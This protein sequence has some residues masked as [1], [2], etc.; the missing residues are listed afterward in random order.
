MSTASTTPPPTEVADSA[1]LDG[2]SRLRI[3]T[4]LAVIVLYTEIAPLQ[5]IMVAAALQ[6]VSVSFPTVGANLNWSIIILGLVGSAV[7]PVLGKL[8]DVAGKRRIFVLCG[9]FF[10]A[11]CLID[12]LTSSWALFLIGRGLQAFA[13]ATMIIAF[14]LIRDLM[15]RKYVPVGLGVAAAGAGFSGVLGP[16]LGGFLV[17]HFGWR[18]MFW[19]L[20][21]FVL[22]MT[23]IVLMLVPESPLRVR[24]RINPIGA[25][26]LSA[27]TLLVLL[28]LDK[29]QDWGWGRPTALAWVIA[30]VVLLAVFFVVESRIATP[31]MD[32]KLLRNPRVSLV[33]LIG[34]LGGALLAVHGYAVSYMTQTPGAEQ[35]KSTVAQGVIAQVK[36][37]NGVTLPASAV[38]VTLDPGYSYG[39]GFGLLSYAL[40]LGMWAGL[41]GMIAGPI[42]GLLARR[43]GARIP[44]I[45]GLVL[46]TVFGGVFALAVPHYSWSL[47]L[48]FSVPFGVGFGLFQ[49]AT[50][51]LLV[52]GVPAEQQGITTGMYGVTTG[53]AAAIGLA[54]TT[55]LLNASPV[56]AHI[57]VM[58]HAAAQTIPQVFADRGYVASYW[59]LSGATLIAL[60]VALFM[61]HGRTPATGGATADTAESTV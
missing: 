8:S 56:V 10:I 4:V 30:G 3:F 21:G 29:G 43:V 2:A 49:A 39:N 18:A 33:L 31:L 9:V 51:I 47:F 6:K 28:Y 34:L 50:P 13:V 58:G 41:I 14:G 40:H 36:S 5:Y 45:I 19:F 23:P 38:K 54:V 32:P 52:E 44:L 12:A 60:V 22:V 59:V 53:M 15:P 7:S 48:V 37:S 57:D 55:A 1:R 24:Q 27:G 25:V 26:L 16:V 35:L 11:G 17:D 20:G 61:R 46:L 42:G